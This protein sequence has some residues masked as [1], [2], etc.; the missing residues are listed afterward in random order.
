MPLAP[1]PALAL[2]LVLGLALT[3]SLAGEGTPQI[4]P[5]EQPELAARS[6]RVHNAR[7]FDHSV[8]YRRV[9]HCGLYLDECGLTS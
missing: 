9:L 5:S 3:L 8:E 6:D 4:E 2:A 7:F 1:P